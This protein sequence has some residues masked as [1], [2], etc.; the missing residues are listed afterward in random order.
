MFTRSPGQPSQ[1]PF[2][3]PALAAAQNVGGVNGGI[4]LG[5]YA[6]NEGAS[7]AYLTVADSNGTLYKIAVPA[8]QTVP[9]RGVSDGREY[10]GQL[11][12]TPSAALDVTVELA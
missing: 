5:L 1:R 2:Y 4:L 6:T 10:S 12:I 3:Y 11:S 9:I 8:G 7:T